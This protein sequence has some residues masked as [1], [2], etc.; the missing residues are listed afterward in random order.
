MLARYEAGIIATG[1]MKEIV[2]AAKRAAEADADVLI[3]GESGTGKSMLA[4]AIHHWSPRARFPEVSVVCGILPETRFEELVFGSERSAT[5]HADRV[6]VGHL[7]LA[8]KGTVII[9][10]M[11]NMSRA[12]QT[13]LL[14][15]L[16]DSAIQRNGEKAAITVDIRLIATTDRNLT[17]AVMLGTFSR[18]LLERLKHRSLEASAPSREARRHSGTRRTVFGALSSSGKRSF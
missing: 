4:H 13:R 18:E 2:A 6:V 3:E 9:E 17:R 11:G 12:V 7:E 8:N 16:Q 5:T 10:E 14:A 1:G 15:A